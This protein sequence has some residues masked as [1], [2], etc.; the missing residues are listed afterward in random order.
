M[1]ASRI[2]DQGVIVVIAAGNAGQDGPWLAS[3]GA[4]GKHVLTVGSVDPSAFPAQT[5]SVVYS[6]NGESNSTEVTYVPGNS[7]FPDTIVNL[8]VVPLTLNTPVEND[9]CEPLPSDTPSFD[10]SIVLV[11]FG[12]CTVDTKHANVAAFGAQYVL[13]YSSDN[14]TESA[15]SL[16]ATGLTGAVGADVGKSIIDAVVEGGNVTA[17]FDIQTTHYTGAHSAAGGKPALYT[18]WGGTFD[19]ALKPDISAPGSKILSTYPTDDYR[20]LSGTSMATPYI[21]GVA[22]L[23]VGKFGGRAAHADDPDWAKRV[24]ARITNSG[25]SVPWADWVPTA[26][27]YGFWAPAPQVGAGLVDAASVLGYTTE[28]G[29]E[30]RKFEL[31]DTANF[32]GTHS[33][34]ITNHGDEAVTYTF[35]LQDAGGFDSWTPKEPGEDPSFG[36]PG[37]PYYAYIN[38]VEMTPEVSLPDEITIGPGETATTEYAAPLTECYRDTLLLTEN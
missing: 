30:G 32:V 14:S 8:S 12:G 35:S 5:F 4:S 33:L 23:Y 29:F 13:F 10:D 27:D 15:A 34:D 2:V 3:N 28:L 37:I 18:S 31:N 19:L 36:V 24:I 1:V 26:K 16:N 38:P 21:A 7:A 20:V 11:K 9:A 25:R 17:S 6:L 22:A